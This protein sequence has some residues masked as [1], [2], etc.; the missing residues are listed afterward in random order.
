MTAPGFDQFI[1][2]DW[3][4]ASTPKRGADSI[5][6]A[7]LDAAGTG[8]DNA[9]LH[10]P[11]TRAE[12]FTLLS[13]LLRESLGEGKR[14]L[15][16]FD[17]PLGYPSGTALALG[18]EGQ[19]WQAMWEFLSRRIEEGPRNG[20][21]RFAVAAEMNRVMTGE[22][23]PF[24]G[25]PPSKEGPFLGQR[26]LRRHG[27]DDLPEKRLI[28][29]RV[30]GAQPVW[31]LYTTGSV[32]SQAL[33]GIPFLAA[34]RALPD[35]ASGCRI[36]PF[37]TGLGPVTDREARLVLAEIYPSLWCRSAGEGQ[38]K[39]AVQVRT[40]VDT[41]SNLQR[42]CQLDRVLSGPADLTAEERTRVEAEEAWILGVT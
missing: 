17:F 4:A 22:A 18:L 37:E 25:C 33:L 1:M 29:A 6:I 27:A 11:P 20:N 23:F 38:I 19:P 14:V 36:W 16:G 26:R 8:G 9:A 35:L 28:D 13:N 2:V 31:K 39:D 7:V 30:S 15:A 21:N 41:L 3:S 34:L 24:W 10:N 5:W 42:D 12:A 32:G 40:V